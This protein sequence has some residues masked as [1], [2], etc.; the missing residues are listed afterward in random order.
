[1][2]SDKTKQIGDAISSQLAADR[3][4]SFGLPGRASIEAKVNAVKTVSAAD[5]SGVDAKSDTL[6]ELA[7]AFMQQY[8]TGS[9]IAK[10]QN[11]QAAAQFARAVAANRTNFNQ[12][13][14]VG[15]NFVNQ[16]IQ[17]T[18]RGTQANLA[19]GQQA[20]QAAQAAAIQK[21]AQDLSRSFANMSI[22]RAKK[23]IL[24]NTSL[25]DRSGI[26]AANALQQKVQGQKEAIDLGIREADWQ[27]T[28][29]AIKLVGGIAEG[30]TATGAALAKKS[31][32]VAPI[33]TATSGVSSS[34]PASASPIA[35]G[36]TDTTAG[37]YAPSSIYTGR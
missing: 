18:Q 33:D 24:D 30:A 6:R 32:S 14:N 34:S 11:A 29:N 10:A 22:A 36:T 7:S 9:D 25:A 19:Q 2:A 8:A 12:L 5:W 3:Q 23:Q 4:Q 20:G 28:L 1:M 31:S 17:N 16:S 37:N 13:Q 15:E 26:E 35:T 27:N 21:Y